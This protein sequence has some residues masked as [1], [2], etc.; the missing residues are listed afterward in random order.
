M[1][2]KPP[3]KKKKSIAGKAL[4]TMIMILIIAS[5]TLGIHYISNNIEPEEKALK[6]ACKEFKKL[7]EEAKAEELKIINITE[8]PERFYIK[9]I[10]HN[11]IDIRKSDLA[12]IR[13]NGKL[14]K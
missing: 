8:D 7:G 1:K 2:E 6:I 12:I 10:N 14:V 5:V 11:S 4:K 13:V 3:Q 9:S